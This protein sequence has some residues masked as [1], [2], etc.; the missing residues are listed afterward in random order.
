VRIFG[1]DPLE[2]DEKITEEEIRMMVDVGE[3]KGAIQEAKK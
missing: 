2:E 1:F 3:K